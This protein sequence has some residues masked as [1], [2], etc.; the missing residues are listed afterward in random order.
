MQP[1]INFNN[2]SITSLLIYENFVLFTTFDSFIQI[3]EL[4]DLNDLNF[5]PK[6]LIPVN[7]NWLNCMKKLN[8][9]LILGCDDRMVRVFSLKTYKLLEEFFGHEDSIIS[10]E[11]A[12]GMLFSGSNDHS[13]RS[14]DLKEMENRIRERKFMI[15]EDINSRKFEAYSSVIEKKKKKKKGKKGKK[16]KKKGS[17]KKK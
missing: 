11:I 7:G 6:K 3:H 5:L 17:A 15:R 13:I 9:Y 12:D 1:P 16:G 10:L 14:W 8:D 4:S 2:I